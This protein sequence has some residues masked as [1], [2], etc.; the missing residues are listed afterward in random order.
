M[1][2]LCEGMFQHEDAHPTR[3]GI[4]IVETRSSYKII[5]SPQYNFLCRGELGVLNIAE[6]FTIFE[7]TL[8][9]TDSSLAVGKCL[10]V[11]WISSIEI[12]R[13]DE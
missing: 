5:L 7:V 9:Q 3:I 8:G 1:Y 13:G 2:L 11:V 4:P 10:Q 6:Q 12:L